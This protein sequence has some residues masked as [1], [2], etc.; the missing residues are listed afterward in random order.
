MKYLCFILSLILWSPAGAGEAVNTVLDMP[1][2]D[3]IFALETA[4]TNKGLKIDHV[5][6]VGDMLERTGKELD[7]GASPYAQAQILQ[8]CS[9][10]LSREMMEADLSNIRFCPYAVYI[11]SASDEPGQ[12]IIGYDSLPE[13]EMQKVEKL[14]ADIVADAAAF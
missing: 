5:S 9:A 10:T 7:L 12:T 4:I 13:G 2:D 6:H 3:A 1:F 11:Y 8:F 14:L